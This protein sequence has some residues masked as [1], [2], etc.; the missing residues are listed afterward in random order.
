MAEITDFSLPDYTARRIDVLAQNTILSIKKYVFWEKKLIKNPAEK[1][2][3]GRHLRETLCCTTFLWSGPTFCGS[4]SWS[5]KMVA[6]SKKLPDACR[7]YHP[8]CHDH[9]MFYVA[10]PCCRM[11]YNQIYVRVDTSLWRTILS[12]TIWF[13][14]KITAARHI[15]WDISRNKDLKLL[16]YLC[17]DEDSV[18]PPF[19]ERNITCNEA[20]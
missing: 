17:L 14:V 18:Q 13:L 15:I 5:Y 6:Q 1:L 11:S 16:R 20:V 10:R 12:S 7:H 9:G 19:L 2:T 8:H 4:W 3:H